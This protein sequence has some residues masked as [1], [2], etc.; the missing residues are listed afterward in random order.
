MSQQEP[1]EEQVKFRDVAACFSEE[2][3]KILHEWQK[4]FYK[5][6]MKEIHQALIVMGYQIVNADTLL[7]VYKGKE[8]YIQDPQD[9]ETAD[10]NKHVM[11]SHPAVNPDVLF[12]IKHEEKEYCTEQQNPEEGGVCNT[13]SACLPVVTA[14]FSLTTEE[15]LELYPREHQHSERRGSGHRSSSYPFPQT[16]YCLRDEEES[17]LNLMS[18]QKAGRGRSPDPSLR[19]AA[20]PEIVV[21]IKEEEDDCEIMER[22]RNSA[23]DGRMRK[24]KKVGEFMQRIKTTASNKS[25]LWKKNVRMLQST[26]KGLASRRQMESESYPEIR[27]GR[28]IKT[29]SGLSLSEHLNLASS[30]PQLE[31]PQPARP[32]PA[33]PQPARPQPARQQPG[34]PQ[35]TMSQRY[36]EYESHLWNLP[37]RNGLPKTQQILKPYMCTECGK[38]YRLKKEFNRHKETHALVK[39]YTCS[40]CGKNFFRKANLYK[41]Y[42][43]H[44]GE[45]PYTCSLCPKRFSRKDHLNRHTRIHT[46]ERPFKCTECERSFP[47]LSDLNQHRRSRH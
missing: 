30:R 10:M 37:F 3:W 45:K 19:H 23:A 28:R 12:R 39:P 34:R 32:Q 42:K 26:H 2:E 27:L 15:E 22:A 38:S 44:S 21:K 9:T 41:H 4:D 8:I 20:I 40:D 6:V 43:T 7:R 46:G 16:D 18:R 31:R 14:A 35:L 47:W 17:T 13:A 5:N 33:R 11:S 1:D 24:H 29:E 25:L 36:N